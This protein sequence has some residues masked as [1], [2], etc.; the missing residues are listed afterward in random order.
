MRWR[1]RR[2]R[3][4]A[5]GF[6]VGE[7]RGKVRRLPFRELDGLTVRVSE[8]E[9]HGALEILAEDIVDLDLQAA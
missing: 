1:L 3:R 4:A 9:P 2:S 8:V 7:V 5:H 6:P